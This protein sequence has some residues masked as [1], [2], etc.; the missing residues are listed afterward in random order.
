MSL[1]TPHGHVPKDLSR[2]ENAMAVTWEHA[3]RGKYLPHSKTTSPIL[4]NIVGPSISNSLEHI[5]FSIFHCLSFVLVCLLLLNRI[6]SMSA[7]PPD[8]SVA[9]KLWVGSVV[10]VL[11]ATAAVMLRLVARRISAARLW[12]DDWIIMFS[13]VKSFMCNGLTGL[14]FI[15]GCAMGHGYFTMDHSM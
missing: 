1:H 10:S 11:C 13:L 3:K 4:K 2:H 15:V 9:W 8:D 6:S 12:W 14:T 7:I 5:Y